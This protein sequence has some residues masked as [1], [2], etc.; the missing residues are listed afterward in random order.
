MQL[1][2]YFDFNIFMTFNA[3][4][5]AD[6]ISFNNVGT[7]QVSSD[8][9][10]CTVISNYGNAI[11][12]AIEIFLFDYNIFMTF[13]ASLG[14]PIPFRAS[15][16]LMGSPYGVTDFFFP[17][18][19]PS[20]AENAKWHSQGPNTMKETLHC[21]CILGKVL[22]GNLQNKLKFFAGAVIFY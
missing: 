22:I 18:F 19:P 5:L 16:P 20:A 7:L 6:L 4:L 2:Y 14:H 12:N 10:W 3:S 1:K 13:N 11:T 8:S 9:Q 17:R 21:P 15:H